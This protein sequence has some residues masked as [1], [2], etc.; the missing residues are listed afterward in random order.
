MS[1]A[2]PRRFLYRFHRKRDIRTY[3]PIA[4]IWRRRGQDYPRIRDA[5]SGRACFW[6]G[7]WGPNDGRHPLRALTHMELPRRTDNRL[8][9]AMGGYLIRP[10]VLDIDEKIWEAIAG[11]SIALGGRPIDGIET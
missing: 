3:H 7:M 8:Q 10:G 4:D 5:W 9:H 1:A 11:A 6:A 2:T